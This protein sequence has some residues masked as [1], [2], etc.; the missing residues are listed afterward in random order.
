MINFLLVVTICRRHLDTLV[1]D[2]FDQALVVPDV[3]WKRLLLPVEVYQ[4]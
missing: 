3:D 1:E 2:L 4:A